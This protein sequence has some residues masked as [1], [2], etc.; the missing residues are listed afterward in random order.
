MSLTPRSAVVMLRI[1]FG[2]LFPFLRQI[3]EGEDCGNRTNRH[4]SAAVDALDRI[5]VQLSFR[6]KIIFVL[7]RMNAVDRACIHAGRVFRSD[8][9]FSNHLSHENGR[10]A[11]DL[12]LPPRDAVT[13]VTRPAHSVARVQS[14]AEEVHSCELLVSV[15]PSAL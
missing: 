11:S 9:R 10:L 14:L 5:D 12:P 4:A 2:V 7:P 8:T 1:D 13:K 15:R 6:G 3:I